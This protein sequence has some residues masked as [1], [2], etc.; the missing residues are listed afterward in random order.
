MIHKR[1]QRPFALEHEELPEAR[2]RRLPDAGMS[3]RK[4]H[5][6]LLSRP[7]L[8]QILLLK[9]ACVQC[10]VQRS[11]VNTAGDCS[12][13]LNFWLASRSI[14]RRRRLKITVASNRDRLPSSKR[15]RASALTQRSG[16]FGQ[17]ISAKADQTWVLSAVAARAP[18][19]TLFL[20]LGDTLQLINVARFSVG[21]QQ[22]PRAQR[23][24]AGSEP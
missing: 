4:F 20:S 13:A 3:A 1:H 23:T 19:I 21:N 6:A 11:K 9:N 5:G 10:K 7:S 16:S 8:S 15:S 18:E 17:H 24:D 14:L 2:Q 12:P 22:K